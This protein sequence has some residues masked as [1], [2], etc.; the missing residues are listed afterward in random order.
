M[1][2]QLLTFDTKQAHRRR[3]DFDDALADLERAKVIQLQSTCGDAIHL[4][5][6]RAIETERRQIMRGQHDTRIHQ[7]NSSFAGFLDR[8]ANLLDTDATEH[9]GLWLWIKQ[10]LCCSRKTKPKTR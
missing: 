8:H 9:P 3:Q 7:Q 2:V 4:D 5:L 10:C 6:L 1:F